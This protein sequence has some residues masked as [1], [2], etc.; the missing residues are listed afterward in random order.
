MLFFPLVR[1]APFNTHPTR[2]VVGG[3]VV[4]ETV[5]IMLGCYIKHK[6]ASA[7]HYISGRTEDVADFIGSKLVIHCVVDAE[8]KIKFYFKVV[9]PDV[10]AY[11]PEAPEC[12]GF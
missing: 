2:F 4:E 3:L 12:P 9:I 1:I 10:G 8:D 6:D 5:D 7:V 11:Y